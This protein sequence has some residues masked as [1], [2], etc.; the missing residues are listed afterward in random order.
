[1][2]V[3]WMLLKETKKNRNYRK[4]SIVPCVNIDTIRENIQVNFSKHRT[5]VRLCVECIG[6]DHK[7]SL[8]RGPSRSVFMATMLIFSSDSSI[9][10]KYRSNCVGRGVSA[11]VLA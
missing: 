7:S 9:K 5:S 8:R 2:L 6:V 1:M 4:L 3:C 10:E 11:R